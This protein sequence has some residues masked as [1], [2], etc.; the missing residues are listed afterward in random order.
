MTPVERASL[1]LRQTI[2]VIHRVLLIKAAR[3]HDILLPQAVG[4]A[5]VT[6]L[7]LTE[8]KRGTLV[9]FWRKHHVPFTSVPLG[10]FF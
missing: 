8:T 3:V 1:H 4:V 6:I 9:V 5:I 10:S 7:L 2:D